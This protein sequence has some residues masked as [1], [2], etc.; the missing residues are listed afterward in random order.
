VVD[1]SNESVLLLLLIKEISDQL[2]ILAHNGFDKQRIRDV[3]LL[4]P[5]L[6]SERTWS[7]QIWLG[8]EFVTLD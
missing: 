1:I 2:L 6:P 5:L 4:V 3:F 7:L 8:H